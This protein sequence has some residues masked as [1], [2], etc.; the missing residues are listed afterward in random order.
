[1]ISQKWESEPELGLISMTE[2]EK[3]VGKEGSRYSSF[4]VVFSL[5]PSLS[6]IPLLF[7][8]PNDATHDCP[9]YDEKTCNFAE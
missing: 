9:F 6:T 1:M 2:V 8:P 5:H 4:K 3:V 7:H